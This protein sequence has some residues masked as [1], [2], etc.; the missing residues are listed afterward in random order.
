MC[1]VRGKDVEDK[2]R[3]VNDTAT[4]ALLHIAKLH[5]SQI[6]IHDH[7]GNLVQ[8]R[9]GPDFFEFTTPDESRRIEGI[10]HL[11][12]ATRDGSAGALDQF[13]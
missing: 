7:Q 3:A 10:T 5:G 12:K 6:V 11:Q 8:A 13:A 4:D 2:L 9:L 1:G